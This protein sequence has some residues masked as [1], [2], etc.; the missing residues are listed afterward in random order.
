MATRLARLP[1]EIQN[2][3]AQIMENEIEDGNLVPFVLSKKWGP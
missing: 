1:L 3:M 2:S